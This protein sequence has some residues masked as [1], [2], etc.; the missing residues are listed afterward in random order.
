MTQG[1]ITTATEELSVVNRQLFKSE[2]VLQEAVCQLRNASSRMKDASNTLQ[3]LI[4]SNFLQSIK[5]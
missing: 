3:Q 4:D 2:V 1:M 5:I